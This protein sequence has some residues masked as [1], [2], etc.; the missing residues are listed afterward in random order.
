MSRRVSRHVPF[1]D[2]QDT[3][4][5]SNRESREDRD[6]GEDR[7]DIAVGSEAC[8]HRQIEKRDGKTHCRR[9]DRQLYL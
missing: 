2:G 5:E 8:E 1:N 6:D 4:A 3:T 9:C 7:E